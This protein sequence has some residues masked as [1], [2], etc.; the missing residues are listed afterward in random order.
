MSTITDN[1]RKSLQMELQSLAKLCLRD[2]EHIVQPK[3]FVAIYDIKRELDRIENLVAYLELEQFGEETSPRYDDV[4]FKAM[5][6][7]EEEQ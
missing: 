4:Y 7:F 6:V 1:I 2:S 3:G 5:Q